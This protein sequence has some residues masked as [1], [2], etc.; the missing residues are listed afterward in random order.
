[1]IRPRWLLAPQ[2]FKGTLSAAEAADAM[3]EGLR[4][5]SLDVVLDVAPLADGGPGTLDA[6]LVGMPRGERRRLTVRGPLG[7]PVE[8]CWARLDDGRT[9]VVEMA[10]A[11]GLTLVP[12]E[13]RDARAA[14]THGT[15]QLL[16][17]AL[18]AGCE[19][20]IVGLGGSAT[21][22]GGKGALEALGFRFLDADG[23]PL[24]PGG[25][26]LARLARVDATGKHP[27]LEQV[28][29]L[30][31]TDVTTPLLGNDGSARLF[32]PQK[33]ADAAAVEELETALATFCRI[34][35]EATANLPGAG[36]AGGLGYGLAALAGGKLT[37]GY[38]LVARALGMERRVL[39][40]DLVLTGEGRFD[41]QTSMG[42]G[43]VALAR[44]ARAQGTHVVLFAGIVQRDNGP[45]LSLFREVVELSSQARPG[46]SARETLREAT[47]KWALARLGG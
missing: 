44:L 37:S 43:P 26:S 39:L 33:G 45:E 2:E 27:R 32:G 1:M 41:R 25:A 24:P 38:D 13:Q 20:L 21:T 16:R 8:A 15:G 19:R 29:L 10:Q 31:A 18:D 14:C 40:A 6:L 36:A 47:A 35:D 5:A 23:A 42:K 46:A 30:I 12:P 28:E 11:S 22:D 7:A 3:A 4:Q 9:A 34:V 17:E